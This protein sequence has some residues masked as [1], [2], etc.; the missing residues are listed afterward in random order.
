MIRRLP[1]FRGAVFVFLRRAEPP[2]ESRKSPE[3]AEERQQ[4]LNPYSTPV[5]Q[6]EPLFRPRVT[7]IPVPTDC[8]C[9]ESIRRG[10]TEENAPRFSRDEPRRRTISETIGKS[11]LPSLCGTFRCRRESGQSGSFFPRKCRGSDFAAQPRNHRKDNTH[12][13]MNHNKDRFR[14]RYSSPAAGDA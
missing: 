9:A 3:A 10:G 13:R 14:P 6:A 2:R 8:K 4:S 7:I 11:R 12:R 1:V 5:T